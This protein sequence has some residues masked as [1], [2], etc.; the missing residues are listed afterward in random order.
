MDHWPVSQVLGIRTRSLNPGLG[1]SG[2]RRSRRRCSFSGGFPLRLRRG[3]V[4]ALACGSC[5]LWVLCVEESRVYCAC[6]CVCLYM[7]MMLVMRRLVKRG[8]G[9]EWDMWSESSSLF[10]SN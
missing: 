5:S 8:I 6:V 1:C 2:T 9:F 10:V 4:A 7:Y 3:S